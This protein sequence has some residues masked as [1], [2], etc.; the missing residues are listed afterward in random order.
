MLN[1]QKPHD[2]DR[3]ALTRLMFDT[4]HSDPAAAKLWIEN[5]GL[6]NWRV[7]KEDGSQLSGA[8]LLVSMGQWFGGREVSMT[9]LA[10]VAV[11]PEGRG[12]KIGQTLMREAL[13]EMRTAKV[14]L[15]TLYGS[16][17]SFY[18]R[19]G[20]ER[21]GSRY[22]AEVKLPTMLAR[23]GPLEVRALGV[24]DF[25]EVEKLRYQTVRHQGSLVRGPYLW[26]R[27]RAPRGKVA[28]GYGFYRDSV[29]EGY[30]YAIKKFADPYECVLEITDL[31]IAG[32]DALSTFL[33]YLAGHRTMISTARW[34]DFPESPLLLCI[35]EPWQYTLQLQEHWMLRLVD[36][37]EAFRQRG[38]AEH[39]QEK[40]HLEIEDPW[41]AENSGA[42]VLS[43][44]NGEGHL[45]RGGSG[46]LK[47]SIGALASLYSGFMSAENLILARLA[48]GSSTIA[49]RA[50]ALFGGDTP[51]LADFF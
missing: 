26:N 46:E 7:L 43:V 34:P 12:R 21:A 50:T 39:L 6:S 20:Y 1:F 11:S 47:L 37:E 51:R 18:R 41:F 24:A 10:G 49:A 30:V 8:L 5:S 22:L 23:G 35:Q 32:P 45:E 27:L 36:I 38:F 40:L 15:S 33:G 48:T 19:C 42:W 3:E 44:H 29:L 25:A 2:R 16:T 13:N 28:K 14:A 4:F 17:T 9:G 31:V